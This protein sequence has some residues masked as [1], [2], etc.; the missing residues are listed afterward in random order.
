MSRTRRNRHSF[1]LLSTQDH[2]AIEAAFLN[3]ARRPPKVEESATRGSDGW[4]CVSRSR[5][6]VGTLAEQLPHELSEWI[7]PLV[8]VSTTSD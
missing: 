3:A 7:A 6:M 5:V 2:A 4:A 8:V 1:P